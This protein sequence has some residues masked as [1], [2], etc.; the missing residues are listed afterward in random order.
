VIIYCWHFLKWIKFLLLFT[1]NT[2]CDNGTLVATTAN[3][4]AEIVKPK[5]DD[6]KITNVYLSRDSDRSTFSF[7]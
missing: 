5:I 7:H 4:D 2:G 3:S 6:G 1:H